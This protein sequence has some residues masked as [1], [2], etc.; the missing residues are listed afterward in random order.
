MGSGVFWLGRRHSARPRSRATG[1]AARQ[2]RR[3]FLWLWAEAGAF[4]AVESTPSGITSRQ[5]DR[6]AGT[7]AEFWRIFGSGRDAPPLTLP[8]PGTAASQSQPARARPAK[9]PAASRK[10][11]RRGPRHPRTSSGLTAAAGAAM[12]VKSGNSRSSVEIYASLTI[13][14]I[15]IPRSAST[16]APQNAG[17][18][19]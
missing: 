4:T 17:P 14:R 3:L 13:A 19:R 1:C 7:H 12:P 8:G 5:S 9:K 18:S 6:D 10:S 16:I 15:N 11:M 2:R